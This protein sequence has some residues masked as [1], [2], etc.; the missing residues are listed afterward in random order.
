MENHLTTSSSSK[1]SSSQ[2][3]PQRPAAKRG[4]RG[5]Q[6]QPFRL[7]TE[8]RGEM[9]QQALQR[10]L[11]EST[12]EETKHRIRV[13]QGLPLTTDK[14]QVV[15][16]PPPK[17]Q[18]K[19]VGIKLHTQRRAA[20]RAEFN[21]VI[22]FKIHWLKHQKQRLEKIQK[23]IEEEEVRSLRKEMIPKAQLMP[24]F[25]RPFYPQRSRRALTVP[26]EPSFNM[27]RNKC[28]WRH[29]SCRGTP[30]LTSAF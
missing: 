22:N 2:T 25:D 17:E 15:Y 6:P 29:N 18:T 23:V 16:K 27:L 4:S 21:D 20:E 13:A 5:G 3:S 24:F 11:Q 7:L 30:Q 26:K 12:A 8:T 1:S 28:T 10:R 19:P 14:P 9:K